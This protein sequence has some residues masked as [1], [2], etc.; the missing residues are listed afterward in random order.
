MIY[1]LRLY[2]VVPGRMPALH[3]RFQNHTLG[4]FAKHG[5]KVVGFWEALV[6]TSNVLSYLLAFEDLAHR[7]RAWA[8]FMADEDWKRVRDES[9]RDGPIVARIRNELWQPT[10]YSPLR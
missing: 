3:A 1:E 4:F 10:P 5:I 7:E 2:E 6:G 9:Q 8:A